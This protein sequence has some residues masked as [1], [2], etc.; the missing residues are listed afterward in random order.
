MKSLRNTSTLNRKCN[1]SVVPQLLLAALLTVLTTTNVS[2]SEIGNLEVTVQSI[3]NNSGQIVLGLHLSNEDFPDKPVEK[4]TCLIEN[5]TCKIVLE[6]LA[7][8]AYAIAL[9]HD[10][11]SD[12]IF[13]HG[14]LGFGQKEGFGISNNKHRKFSP[15]R[16]RDAKFEFSQSKQAMVISIKY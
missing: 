3:K 10:E 12:E 6:K 4:F 14:F 11:N 15:P 7:Y 8:G 9:F 1:S 16:F 2:A 5:N 13:D